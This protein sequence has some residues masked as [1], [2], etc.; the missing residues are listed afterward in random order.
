MKLDW[1]T[2]AA[3]IGN[4][5]LLLWLLKRFLY[6]PI[7]AAMAARQQRIAAAL[8]EAQTQAAAAEALQREYLA[9]QQELATSR[10]TWLTQAREEVAAQR[11]TWLIQAR[12]E[13]DESR[14]R[15][16]T[17]LYREQQDFQRTLQRE[18]NQRLLALA[19]RALRDLG[20][21]DLEAQMASAL[22]ARL[23]TLDHE[24]RQTLAQA[25]RDGCAIITAFPLP[26]LQRRTLTDGLQQLFGPELNPDFRTDPAASPGI[27]LETPSQRLAWTLDGYLDGF[28]AELQALIPPSGS[29]DSLAHDHA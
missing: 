10:E 13:V 19:R 1:F 2:V 25:A 3:Q 15:W 24:T 27:T 14:E 7:L 11:Q 22:L 8:M 17:E 18:A 9:R 12:T 29:G 23:Q 21:A 26:E 28:A 6:R 4:F 5:L 20:N 16:R